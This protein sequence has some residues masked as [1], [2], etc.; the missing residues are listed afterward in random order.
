MTA[1][2]AE[3][4]ESLIQ[5]ARA[6]LHRG[7]RE[8][9]IGL[10]KRALTHR[11]D[12][13]VLSDLAVVLAQSGRAEDAEAALRRAL[14]LRES[15]PEA[16]NNL[17]L[18]LG[19]RGRVV[20]AERALRR[21]LELR[22]GY[23]EAHN[24]LGALLARQGRAA[25][26]ESAYRRALDLR[27][28]YPEAHNNLGVL[29][30]RRGQVAEAEA[31][32]RCALALRESYPEAHSNLG[33]LL[34]ARGGTREAEAEYRRA[35]ELAPDQ[36]GA[37][38]NLGLLQL[39]LG[40]YDEG[41]R[42]YETRWDPAWGEAPHRQP[43]VP[44]PRWRGESLAGKSLLLMCEQGLG[45]CLQFVRYAPLV[46]E[47]LKPG[48]LTIRCPA[49]LAALFEAVH[50]I[51]AIEVQEEDIPV[52]AHDRWCFLGSLPFLLGTISIATVPAALPYLAAP[53]DRLAHWRSRLPEAGLRVGLVWKASGTQRNDQRSPGGLAALAPLW[54]VPGVA[55][56]SLQK[57]AGEEEAAAGIPGCPLTHVGTELG[58]FADSAACLSR[59]DLLISVDTA[60][61]H[62]NAALARPTWILLP[63]HGPDWRWL[64]EREDSPWYPGVVRL[65]R[66]RAPADWQAVIARVGAALSR[67]A[68][69]SAE[70]R[71]GSPDDQGLA[72]TGE[73]RSHPVQDE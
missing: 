60:F 19:A 17:G 4:A 73:D 27:P 37:R 55:F 51:D 72:G 8:E 44:F 52:G 45:D 48:R 16:H 38:W 47:R 6:A 30:S 63:A 18:L 62:L 21:A 40:R 34:A 22:E 67:L 64:R 11:E 50:G 26:A 49:A 13:G 2:G 1:A 58:D 32:H 39:S 14:E 25:E 3:S 36:H 7:R 59:L 57:G 5:S 33:V 56:I 71:A 10:L 53:A 41:W 35:L 23:P 9:A 61:A 15:Y 31:A 28:T 20:D 46:K 66:Q 65:F 42:N 24:N 70:I 68:R 12:P 54:Q 43:S 69:G 29:L